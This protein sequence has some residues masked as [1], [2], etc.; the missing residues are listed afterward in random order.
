MLACHLPVHVVVDVVEEFLGAL[1]WVVEEAED[2]IDEFAIG[3]SGH[4]GEE[5]SVAFVSSF[6]QEIAK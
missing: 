5:P 3:V 1:W 6:V 2:I 4:V